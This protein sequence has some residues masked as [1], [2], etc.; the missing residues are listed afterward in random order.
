MDSDEAL[1]CAQRRQFPVGTRLGFAAEQLKVGV[2]ML[3]YMDQ[4]TQEAADTFYPGYAK[5]IPT[6]AVNVDGRR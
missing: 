2:H 6:S 1:H 4:T 5:A 3:A